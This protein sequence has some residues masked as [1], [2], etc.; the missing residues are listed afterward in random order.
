MCR[1]VLLVSIVLLIYF[2]SISFCLAQ[3][4]TGTLKYFGY[5]FGDSDISYLSSYNN[6]FLVRNI[7]R[8]DEARANGAKGILDIVDIFW[9]QNSPNPKPLWPDWRT[10]WDSAWNN[11]FRERSADIVGLYVCDEAELRTNYSDYQQ[12][13]SYIKSYT[14]IPIMLTISSH[15]ALLL[16]DGAVDPGGVKDSWRNMTTDGKLKIP[17][18]VDWLGFDEYACW[19]GS[20]C[21][22]SVSITDKLDRLIGIMKARGGK[23]YVIPDAFI[24]A[25][26]NGSRYE[27]E[28]Y[29][30]VLDQKYFDLCASRPDCILM[31]PFLWK[32][33]ANYIGINQMPRLETEFK[34]MGDMILKGD[35]GPTS[36]YLGSLVSLNKP[37][38]ASKSYSTST[39]EKIT[40]GDLSTVWNSGDRAPQW[41]QIDLGS[42]HTITGVRM[43]ITQDPLG[44]TNHELWIAGNDQVFSKIRTFYSKT[45]DREVLQHTF[46]PNR[47]GVRFVKVVTTQSPSW[48]AWK[49]VEVFTPVIPTST[50]IPSPTPTL[51]DVPSPTDIPSVTPSPTDTPC[52]PR[53]D[54]DCNGVV[55][56]VDLS[57][58]LSKFGTSGSFPE[59]VDGNGVVNLVDLSILLSNFGKSV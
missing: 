45:T 8:L 9:N 44:V 16:T 50:P 33:D 43:I 22:G 55:N 32:Y 5:Y 26:Y 23:V 38:T 48:V 39:P 51:T 35:V 1:N 11:G 25:S 7:Q 46:Y 20:E 4:N 31:F 52:G 18:D 6:I 17:A 56:L 2:F 40:D 13:V 12:V 54:V 3:E 15:A 29:R 59:D 49:E 30:M 19:E 28:T 21:F 57:R 24:R 27:A 14:N 47:S 36:N 37:A 58:L 42:E 34:H 53:G 41:A 10:R